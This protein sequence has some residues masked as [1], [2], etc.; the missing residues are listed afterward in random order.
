[1]CASVASARQRGGGGGG[2][3]GGER[4]VQG[5]EQDGDDDD[6]RGECCRARRIEEPELHAIVRVVAPSKA[7]ASRH[8]VPLAAPAEQHEVHGRTDYRL[9]FVNVISYVARVDGLRKI[10]TRAKKT[11]EDF[12]SI[13]NTHSANTYCNELETKDLDNK[14]TILNIFN[15]VQEKY[16]F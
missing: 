7:T 3:G 14:T 1:M 8:A 9:I 2:G 5:Q 13:L 12:G 15:S 6:P 16:F 11:R 10:C 4:N